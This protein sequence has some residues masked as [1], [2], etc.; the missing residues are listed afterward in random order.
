MPV[1]GCNCLS[2]PQA[3]FRLCFQRA[4]ILYLLHGGSAAD[5]FGPLWEKTLEQVPVDDE[6]QG[7]LYRELISW[8]KSDELFTT[9]RRSDRSGAAV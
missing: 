1:S 8:A 4:L 9:A 3:Q 2:N 7:E 6:A 5:G